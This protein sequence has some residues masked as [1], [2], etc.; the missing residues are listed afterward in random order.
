M[1]E[2]RERRCSVRHGGQRPQ[3]FVMKGCSVWPQC[4]AVRVLGILGVGILDSLTL[5][6]FPGSFDDEVRSDPEGMAGL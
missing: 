5:K 3:L 4:Q 6:V 2:S 1:L